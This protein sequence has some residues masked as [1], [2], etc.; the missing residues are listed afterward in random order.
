MFRRSQR[1]AAAVG[2]VLLLATLLAAVPSTAGAED[3]PISIRGSIE[4]IY[5]W[6]V[7]PEA[8]VELL[9]VADAVIAT[10]VADA[11]GA[12]HFKDGEFVVFDDGLRLEVGSLYRARVG[13]NVS[14]AVEVLGMPALGT[15]S[16]PDQAFYDAQTINPGY[17]YIETR[18]GT[19]LSMNVTLPDA[20]TYGPGPYPTVVEYSG[21]SPS[22]PSSISHSLAI[23]QFLGYATVAVN[24]RGTG[25][26]GGAYWYWE[27]AQATDGYDV[28]EAIAAQSWSTDVGLVGISFS[29][30]SQLC[31]ARTNP[32]S[33]AAVTAMSV[34]ADTY[35]S[36]LYPGGILNDGFALDWA[37][38]RVNEAEPRSLQWVRDQID[39]GDTECESNM[40]PR[41][42]HEPILDE[43]MHM[44]YWE[45][46]GAGL[47]PQPKR[48]VWSGS[49]RAPRELRVRTRGIRSR[50]GVPDL[51]GERRR[52]TRRTRVPRTDSCH[53]P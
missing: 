11:Q 51:L 33:L 41:L 36:T 23:Y 43:V 27:P 3:P 6:D 9:D 14:A 8:T 19:T 15:G 18:D 28:V 16:D 37:I 17:G 2:A 40:A 52:Q 31:V 25:C 35:R 53:A 24:I 47:A 21:Y 48:N 12:A 50:G 7:A 45:E 32:P 30:I 20:A 44:R 26:S 13:T 34:I 39:G 42:Q 22:N 5:V 29:G 10:A 49:V 1:L 38:A 46:R 4:Q